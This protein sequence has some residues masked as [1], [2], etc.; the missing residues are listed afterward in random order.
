MGPIWGGSSLVVVL[1]GFAL[2][3]CLGWQYNDPCLNQGIDYFLL[4]QRDKKILL[5][6]KD[7]GNAFPWKT[8]SNDYTPEKTNMAGWEHP[9]ILIGNLPAFSMG[10]F[11]GE[12][13][14]E[15]RDFPI[16]FGEH[17]KVPTISLAEQQ[18]RVIKEQSTVPQFLELMSF[19]ELFHGSI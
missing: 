15:R 14:V 16:S 11:Y 19:D 3:P 5:C 9:P 1:E 6:V 7:S 2:V 12:L 10:I 8:G 4:R 18:L 13:L 17:G